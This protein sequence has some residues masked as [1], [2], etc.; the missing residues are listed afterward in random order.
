MRLE[1]VLRCFNGLEVKSAN[2][3]GL[4]EIKL[5]VSTNI[6][7]T[8]KLKSEQLRLL[9]K[10]EDKGLRNTANGA[11]VNKEVFPCLEGLNSLEFQ[12]LDGQI[13]SIHLE[14][15]SSVKWSSVEEFTKKIS[16]LLR[17]SGTWELVGH[18]RKRLR[19]K[20]YWIEVNVGTYSGSNLRL[21]D[22]EAEHVIK[23]RM[24]AKEDHQRRTFNL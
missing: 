12:F 10:Y 9:E 15:D 16:E 21:Q 4:Q 14:Y 23:E 11:Y 7:V 6:G 3:V 13:S 24:A 2:E 22:S 19:A 18:S 20:T 1:E 8:S 5:Y 17:L